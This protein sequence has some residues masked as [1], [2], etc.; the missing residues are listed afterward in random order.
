MSSLMT[1]R[2][3]ISPQLPIAADE[4][5]FSTVLD[6]NSCRL[7][8]PSFQ[9]RGDVSPGAL[10]LC[11]LFLLERSEALNRQSSKKRRW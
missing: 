2:Q 3:G 9:K 4:I 11:F 5:G 10:R 6:P 7:E 1:A 8:F